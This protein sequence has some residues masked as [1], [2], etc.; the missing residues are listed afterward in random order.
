MTKNYLSTVIILLVMLFF[1]FQSYAGNNSSSVIEDEMAVNFDE[2]EIYSSFDQINDLVNYVSE[3]E[4]VTYSSIVAEDN[5]LVENVSSSAAM[6]MNTATNDDPTVVGAFWYG[7]IFSA[8]GII[9]VSVV[10]GNDPVQV[11]KAITGCIVSTIVI[12]II[13]IGVEIF[14]AVYGY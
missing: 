7:C 10:T 11:K 12:P 2:S 8:V 5:L 1:S 4:D 3:N 14:V 13:Y 6:V 9:A